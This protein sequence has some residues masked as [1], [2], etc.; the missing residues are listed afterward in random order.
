MSGFESFLAEADVGF[1]FRR[2]LSLVGERAFRL[3]RTEKALGRDW[4]VFDGMPS[5]VLLVLSQG[6]SGGDDGGLDAMRSSE[7][8][9]LSLGIG[10]DDTSV[11]GINAVGGF[12]ILST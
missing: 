3:P 4:G 11:G 10:V 5:L 9:A 6:N 12:G 7:K 8:I 2:A 1:L